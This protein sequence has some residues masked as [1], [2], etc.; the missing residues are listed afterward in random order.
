M[1]VAVVSE[2]LRAELFEKG[3]L[4]CALLSPF[5]SSLLFDRVA[6]KKKKRLAFL[7][8]V[9]LLFLKSAFKCLELGNTI[10]VVVVLI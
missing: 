7:R 2:N 3:Q 4:V 8:C 10:A 6:E 9:C 5:D 1:T